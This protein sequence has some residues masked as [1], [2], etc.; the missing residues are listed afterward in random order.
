MKCRKN[1]ERF[2]EIS[3]EFPSSIWQ[4]WSNPSSLSETHDWVRNP[5]FG[6]TN[7]SQ[8]Y[9]VCKQNNTGEHY[10]A[11]GSE[12]TTQWSITW[13]A[14]DLNSNSASYDLSRASECLTPAVNFRP[15]WKSFS[16]LTKSKA[17]NKIICSICRSSSQEFNIC[18][19]RNRYT[20]HADSRPHISFGRE[21]VLMFK[22][23]LCWSDTLLLK[24]GPILQTGNS[25]TSVCSYCVSRLLRQ[26]SDLTFD[27]TSAVS[28][29]RSPLT[30]E[31]FRWHGL[32][33][34]WE[35]ILRGPPS[36]NG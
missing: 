11:I 2:L 17:K 6:L 31:H 26:L 25:R 29:L 8:K 16:R 9:N 4:Y 32:L 1:F 3:Q 34:I 22:S 33:E 7:N 19:K 13:N 5:I 28:G 20:L 18:A 30:C 15:Q 12:S 10:S 36:K 23:T 35:I 24:T 27:S 21:L 14:L